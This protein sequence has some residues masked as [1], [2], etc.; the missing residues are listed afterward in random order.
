M[1]KSGAKFCSKECR[2]EYRE[3]RINEIVLLP[4]YLEMCLSFD[5]CAQCSNGLKRE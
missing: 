2:N 4:N 3:E 5:L 1:E